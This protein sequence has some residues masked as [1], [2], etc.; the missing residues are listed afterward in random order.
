M[1]QG[2]GALQH[3]RKIS[4]HRGILERNNNRSNHSQGNENARDQRC[5]LTKGEEKLTAYIYL[6]L[7]TFI[8]RASYQR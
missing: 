7:T 1:N 3:S 6:V 8:A 4:L 5:V 2:K